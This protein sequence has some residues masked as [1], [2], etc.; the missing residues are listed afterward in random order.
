HVSH[1]TAEEIAGEE[2]YVTALGGYTRGFDR[3]LRPAR[4]AEILWEHGCER[5]SVRLNVYPH[6][7]P[8]YEAVIEWGRGTYPTAYEARLGPQWF[9][10]SLAEYERRIAERLPQRPLLYTYPRI[11]MWARKTL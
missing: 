5:P 2:P 11:L 7:M 3:V 1:R 6:L 8:G 9:A 4:Y 10:P